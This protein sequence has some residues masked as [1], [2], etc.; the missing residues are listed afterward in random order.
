MIE[1]QAMDEAFALMDAGAYEQADEQLLSL[2]READEN[3]PLLTNV[4]L[5]MTYTK[6]ALKKFQDA[7]SCGRQL[8]NLW[9][10]TADAHI[11]MHQLAM[12]ERLAGDYRAALDWLMQEKR[13]L[14]RDFPGDALRHGTNLYEWGYI[15]YLQKDWERSRALLEKCLELGRESGDAMLSGCT[16]RALGEWHKSQKNHA[17][18][19]E[20]WQQAI[21]LFREAGDPMACREIE[22][23]LNDWKERKV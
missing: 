18:A 11:A 3:D 5:L 1:R 2:L 13:V 10:E 12:V 22:G 9:I 19:C 16:L 20:Y 14:D 15:A 4:L 7:R 21:A 8:L 17:L 23:W 6:S